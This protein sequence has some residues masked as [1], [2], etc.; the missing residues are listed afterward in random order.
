MPV[1]NWKTAYSESETAQ[2]DME[3]L[4][5]EYESDR[6]AKIAEDQQVEA[7]IQQI[8]A[9][10]AAQQAA[11]SRP[12]SRQATAAALLRLILPAVLP[13]QRPLSILEI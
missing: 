11:L 12:S 8:Y 5:A 4:K 10:L 6:D 1:P 13:V 9:Q 3:A 7:E 2:Q